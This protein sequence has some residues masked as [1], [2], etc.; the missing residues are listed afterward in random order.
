MGQ[1]EV[2]NYLKAEAKAG[3]WDWVTGRDVALKLGCKTYEVTGDLVRLA[4]FGYLETKR[5]ETLNGWPG[6]FRIKKKYVF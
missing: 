6:K 1:I 4:N 2:F 3:R 5:A